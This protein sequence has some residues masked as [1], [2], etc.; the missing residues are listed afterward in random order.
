MLARLFAGDRGTMFGS[1]PHPGL[2][3]ALEVLAWS[4]DHVGKVV[5]LLARLDRVDP[6]SML[7]RT[8]EQDH[9]SMNRPLAS[10]KGIFHSW[11][12]QTGAALEARIQLLHQ[13]RKTQSEVAWSVMLSMLPE[14]H[15]VSFQSERPVA[16]D[17]A[18]NGHVAPVERDRKHN[19]GGRRENAGGR[20]TRR[21]E[22]GR[23]APVSARPTA[24]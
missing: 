23:T 2:L 17:W 5:P 3:H 10:L 7:R 11:R 4:Q 9:R 13:L 1:S 12:P 6:G 16:R 22:V 20:R 15:G 18:E 14:L 8:D 24:R 21:E 19:Q